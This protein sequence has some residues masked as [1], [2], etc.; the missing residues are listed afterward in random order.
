MWSSCVQWI[1]AWSPRT[2]YAVGSVHKGLHLR[3]AQPAEHRWTVLEYFLSASCLCPHLHSLKSCHS[4]ILS[5]SAVT[6]CKTIEWL[7]EQAT[8]L[9]RCAAEFGGFLQ[10]ARRKTAQSCKIIWLL[11]RMQVET[12]LDFPLQV[13]IRVPRWSTTAFMMQVAKG[14][15]TCHYAI[16]LMLETTVC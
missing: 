9:T 5:L 14:E 2:E 12:S 7:L 10:G 16:Y 15:K 1:A 13:Q 8:F 4:H 11:S 6:S 3:G